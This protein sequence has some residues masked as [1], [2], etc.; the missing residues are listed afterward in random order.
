MKGRK[1]REHL[2]GKAVSGD[3]PLFSRG[4]GPCFSG[5]PEQGVDDRLA[6]IV[7]ADGG[8]GHGIDLRGLVAQDFRDERLYH[9]L[10]LPAAVAVVQNQNLGDSAPFHLDRDG[11][12][13]TRA[14]IEAVSKK[15]GLSFEDPICKIPFACPQGRRSSSVR[16]NTEP[17]EISPVRPGGSVCVL[18]AIPRT[19]PSGSLST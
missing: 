7:A 17:R 4:S 15:E 12:K 16:S 2:K 18:L 8:S 9:G 13:E 19:Q 10:I 14:L 6:Q 3:F 1:N 5:G 11:D